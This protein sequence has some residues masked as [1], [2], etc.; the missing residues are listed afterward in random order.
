MEVIAVVWY[1]MMWCGGGEP[2]PAREH[3]ID[4]M[5]FANVVT[6][7]TEMTVMTG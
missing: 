1:S 2:P 7:M 5:F 3:A 6:S 4:E